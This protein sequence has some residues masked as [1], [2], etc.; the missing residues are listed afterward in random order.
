MSYGEFLETVDVRSAMHFYRQA[1]RSA[2]RNGHF[3]FDLGLKIPNQL[4]SISAIRVESLESYFDSYRNNA[5]TDK[6][7]SIQMNQVWT[8]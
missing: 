4:P 8:I 5:N 1:V 7:I 6:S 3:S 2:E